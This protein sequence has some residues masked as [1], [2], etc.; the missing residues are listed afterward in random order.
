MARFAG[1]WERDFK[2]QWA[3]SSGD[4]TVGKGEVISMNLVVCTSTCL[5]CVSNTLVVLMWRDNV[6][7][8]S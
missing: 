8:R 1:D 4:R 2:S 3:S 5:L 6:K 7:S